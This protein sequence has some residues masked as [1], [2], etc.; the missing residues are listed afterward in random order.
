MITTP[1]MG[2]TVWNL[3]ADVFDHSQLANTISAI[4]LHEHS[5]GK[6]VQIGT[7]GIADGAITTSKLASGAVNLVKLAAGVGR[8][9]FVSATTSR[10]V[11]DGQLLDCVGG[12]SIALTPAQNATI[13]IVANSVV[14]PSTAV[15]ITG[16]GG[17][18][19]GIGT[20][21]SGA[22]SVLLGSPSSHLVFYCY[23]GTNWIIVSGQ[24]Y[25]PW[26]TLPI[27]GGGSTWSAGAI[28]P[29]YR[30][31]DDRVWFRG[32]VTQTDVVSGVTLP[33]GYRPGGTLELPIGSS[34]SPLQI[35]SGGVM[36]SGADETATWSLDGVS[37]AP[38]G[39]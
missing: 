34:A 3:V 39:T 8:F 18:I 27:G 31:L 15:T 26:I 37:F 29:A 24:A 14:S 12:V 22:S 5:T 19:Y 9:S 21:I 23:D 33:V 17:V 13:A 1:N 16:G 20:G 2:L 32:I 10:S 36:S 30:K 25:A 35:T 7:G 6:G 4:D 38:V 28:T 11:T